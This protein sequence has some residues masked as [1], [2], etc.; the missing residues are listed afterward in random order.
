[1]LS[2]GKR[3]EA[4]NL[5][6]YDLAHQLGWSASKVPRMENGARG[7]SEVDAAIYL[8]FCGVRREELDELLRLARAG[9]DETWLQEHGQGMPDELRTLVYHE[10]TAATMASY[11]PLLVP[12]LLQTEDYAQSVFEFADV[13]STDQIGTA[14][15][16]RLSRQV[17]IRKPDPPQC[18]FFCTKPRCVRR[19]ARERSCRISC[20]TSCSWRAGRSTRYGWCR[21]AL[22]R[23][24]CGSARSC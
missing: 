5:K 10:T 12:G 9:D 21:Q 11:E 3:R 13:V 20:F 8:T 14:V 7:V 19:S 22:G 4:A 18:Q 6:A 17:V 15:Q 23:T 24:A 16:A 1:M 2:C